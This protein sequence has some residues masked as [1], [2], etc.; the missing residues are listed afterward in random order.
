[1]PKNADLR[2]WPG[3]R[4]AKWLRTYRNRTEKCPAFCTLPCFPLK[5]AKKCTFFRN[6]VKKGHFWSFL[7]V[8]FPFNRKRPFFFREKHNFANFR[9]FKKVF[10]LKLFTSPDMCYVPIPIEFGKLR[11]FELVFFVF[12]S[13]SLIQKRVKFLPYHIS[14]FLLKKTQKK[15]SVSLGTYR[16][17]F[18]KIGGQKSTKS[19]FF[20]PV[21]LKG[22]LFFA[23]N[24]LKMPICTIRENW[25]FSPCRLLKKKRVLFLASFGLKKPTPKKTRKKKIT[26]FCSIE[27]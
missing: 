1:M 8:L 21:R 18:R 19:S 23:K 10:P 11:F 15:S 22:V 4:L 24:C 13:P 17:H 14:P 20:S 7:G 27:F 6:F 12:L 3:S 2:L 16:A 26:F 25:P 9:N 5:K